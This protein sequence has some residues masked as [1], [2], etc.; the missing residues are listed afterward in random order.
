MILRGGLFQP[1]LSINENFI[2]NMI[3]QVR[4]F[5]R[6]SEQEVSLWIG[7]E[8]N[9]KIIIFKPKESSFYPIF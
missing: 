5:M 2:E 1:A 7:E 8:K 3:I 4:K 9:L 6:F